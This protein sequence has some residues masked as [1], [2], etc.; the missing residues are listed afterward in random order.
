MAMDPKPSKTIHLDKFG[1]G[2]SVLCALHC[3][4]TPLLIL[5]L[6]IMARYYLL[7]PWFH[8]LLG[9]LIIPVGSY[10]FWK[11]YQGHG[12]IKVFYLGIPGLLIIAVTPFLVHSLK[13][14]INEAW[15]MVPGS[16][17][18]VYAHWKNYR[19]CRCDAH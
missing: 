7:N 19:Y 15:L 11:G 9:L 4:L 17:L 18:L 12:H 14:P 16:M 10:A 13:I 1:M 5:S 6:P 2:L 8:V 3:V